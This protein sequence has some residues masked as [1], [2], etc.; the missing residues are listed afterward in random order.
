[1]AVD[2]HVR[3]LLF[4]PPGTSLDA[5]TPGVAEACQQ[6]TTQITS[7]VIEKSDLEMVAATEP[8]SAFA[9][10]F[11]LLA[12]NVESLAV[13][14]QTQVILVMSAY[15]KEGR[16]TTVVNLG[17]SLAELGHRVVIVQSDLPTQNGKG[18]DDLKKPGLLAGPA[19]GKPI[20]PGT[21]MPLNVTGG[22]PAAMKELLA[23]LR[24]LT[25]FILLDSPACLQQADAFVLAPLV[26]GVI[27]VVR[28]RRHDVAAQ[29]DIQAQLA[30]LGV[31]VLGAVFNEA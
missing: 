17:Q 21:M 27:Y 25:D 26:D 7:R 6:M 4:V 13:S 28:Q 11:R 20:V 9:E 1:M 31:R 12:V 22:N 10:T 16:T 18:K 15:P 24:P 23:T 19:I 29:R 3:L 2:Q 5:F 30:R 14:Q 8:R